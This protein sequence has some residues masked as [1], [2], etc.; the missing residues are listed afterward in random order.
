MHGK[1]GS[2]GVPGRDGRD[3]REGAKGDRGSSGKTGPQG[4]PGINGKDGSKGEP[5]VQGPTGQ[6]GQ[7][8]E[9]R[10]S[11]IP[12][13]PGTMSYKNWK[14]CAWKLSE[15]KDNGLIKASAFSIFEMICPTENNDLLHLSSF[16]TFVL[17]HKN[18]ALKEIKK[19]YGIERVF[20]RGVRVGGS[21]L[22][23]IWL[24]VHSM[25]LFL[26]H[27]FANS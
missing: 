9:S 8:G 15:N 22:E 11:G 6:K 18:M 16:F 5:G 4:P 25:F 17:I 19:M 20:F 12:G 3:G 24:A 27:F 10:T 13:T 26:I 23:M 14:E 7:R 2:P 1:P 21:V